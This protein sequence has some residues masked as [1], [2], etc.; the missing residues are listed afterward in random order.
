[1]KIMNGSNVLAKD[2]IIS[3]RNEENKK[4][5]LIVDDNPDLTLFFKITLESIGLFVDA[6]NDPVQ[7]L[8]EFT[9]FL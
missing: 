3:L 2:D 4:R 8:S 9:R 6:Y 5:I 1:M 7:A